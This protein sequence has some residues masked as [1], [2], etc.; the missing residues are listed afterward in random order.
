VNTENITIVLKGPK[1]PGNVGF[2]ARC[3]KNMGIDR[4]VVVDSKDL[5]PEEMKQMSTHVAAEPDRTNPIF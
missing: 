1:Y 5:P 4:M 2:V 3:A